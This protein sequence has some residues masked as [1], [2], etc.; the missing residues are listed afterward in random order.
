MAG[1]ACHLECWLLSVQ[2]MIFNAAF[3]DE[4]GCQDCGVE[5]GKIKKIICSFNMLYVCSGTVGMEDVPMGMVL[6]PKAQRVSC[7]VEVRRSTMLVLHCRV[8]CPLHVIVCNRFAACHFAASMLLI[9]VVV[10]G[11]I[12]II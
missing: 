8:K 4:A 6:V 5:H 1:N 3:S 7:E 2:F 12:M 10:G 9:R 11:I